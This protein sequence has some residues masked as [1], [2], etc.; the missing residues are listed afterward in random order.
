MRT[1]HYLN[2]RIKNLTGIEYLNK[3]IFHVLIGLIIYVFK[4]LSVVYGIGILIYFVVNIMRDSH[5]PLVVLRASAYIVAAE[6][7][8]RM[9]DGLIFYETGKYAIILFVAFGLYYHN[10]KKSANIFIVILLLLVPGI[11]VS[12]LNIG[13]E[14]D[15]RK[16][17]LFNISGE[18]CLFAAAL[19]CY[20]RDVK[21]EEYTRILDIMVLPV[22]SLTVYL[23]FYTPDL[24]DVITNAEANFAAS[25]GFGPNQ[26]ATALGLGMFCIFVRL[27][28]PYQNK[29]LRVVMYLM[30]GLITFRA[31]AT[32]SRGGV[33]T[34]LIMSFMFMVSF[35]RYAK[36]RIRY[37]AMIK[38]LVISIGSLA[39]WSLTLL[40]TNDMLYN[41]YTNRNAKGVKEGDFTTGRIEILSIELKAFEENPFF[42]VGTG[43][44]K[45]YRLEN[46][47]KLAASH[48]EITRLFSEHGFFGIIVIILLSLVPF[49]Q[50]M[51]DRR[52]IFIIPLA[53]FWL[54]TISHSAMRIAAPGLLYGLALLK[55]R[56]KK[57]N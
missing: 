56:F 45:Y 32:L 46:G 26:V 15:F 12:Y 50:F 14:A 5:N 36:P 31:L 17:I 24:Q 42:G 1:S 53:L 21:L 3:V 20:N 25:G 2:E 55:V 10:F 43:L 13:F 11:V 48:N 41:K 44:G 38:I 34:A 9:T 16:N 49:A 23:F 30:L 29:V 8:L 27:F 40:A 33:F 28:I 37:K 47:G 35:L 7:F 54:L 39:I 57:E 51:K 18:L 19:F 52:N 22:I 6:V 4:P